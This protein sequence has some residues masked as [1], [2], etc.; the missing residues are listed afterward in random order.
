MF[1]RWRWPIIAKKFGL[2][3][4]LGK[5][6]VFARCVDDALACSWVLC[7]GCTEAVQVVV[8]EEALTFEPDAEAIEIAGGTTT[9]KFLDFKVTVAFDSIGF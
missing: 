2:P 4:A 1:R 6:V 5:T 8:H 9:A 3:K 7:P